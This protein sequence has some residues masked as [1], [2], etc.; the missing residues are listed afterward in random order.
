MADESSP[1]GGAPKSRW[2][3]VL[4]PY[5]WSV[6]FFL[7]PFFIIAKISLSQT[8]IAM[9]PYTPVFDGLATLGQKLS[10]LSFDNYV[11]LTEDALYYSSYLSSLR[12]AAISTLLLLLIGYPVAYAMARAP[13]SL[14]PM[15]VMLVILPFWTSFLIRV[16]AWIGILKPEGLLTLLLQTLHVLGPDEQ[17][18]IYNTETAV[19]IGIVYSY[20]PFMVLPLYS[21]LEKLDATLLEAASDL[22]CPPMKSFWVITFPLSLPGVIAGSFLCFIPIVGE[23]VI[24]DLLG[25]ASTKM[26]G[27]TLWNEFFNNRDWPVSSAVAVVLLVILVVPI[28]IFQNY[29]K[30]V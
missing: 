7:A 25:G 29:Q 15:L 24:P 17:V 11:F 21:A 13:K 3:V 4:V 10:E 1:A 6:V 2:L 23:F 30:R 12:I 9:P 8:A 22:G 16:Y 20:L 26:I 18:R 5:L 19:F 28:V 14:R 27:K